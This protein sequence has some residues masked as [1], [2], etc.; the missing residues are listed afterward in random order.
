M[1]LTLWECGGKILNR[2]NKKHKPSFL[3][4]ISFKAVYTAQGTVRCSQTCDLIPQ[5]NENNQKPIEMLE[6]HKLNLSFRGWS[7][8]YTK[9]CHHKWNLTL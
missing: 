7:H 9:S 2:Q 5:L 8:S 4:S 3:G 1:L 6:N